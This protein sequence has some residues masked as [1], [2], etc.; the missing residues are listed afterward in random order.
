MQSLSRPLVFPD[1]ANIA[2]GPELKWE[3]FR[4]GIEIVRLYNTPG[5]GAS[6]F[7]R[8]APGARLER[9][10]HRGW[11]HVLVLSGSQTD[12]TGHYQTGAMLVHPPGSSHAVSSDEGCIVLA[13]W[14]KPVTFVSETEPE[15]IM[16][17]AR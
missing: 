8:Y 3:P 13:I 9:H 12:D 7:L 15:P 2:T 11:E 10:M 1:L 17:S 14:E 16:S 5:G 4:P 6:A